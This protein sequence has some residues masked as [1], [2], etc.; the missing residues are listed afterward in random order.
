MDWL[1]HNAIAD[2]YGPTFLLVYGAIALVVIVVAYGLVHSCD[3]T[4]LRPPPPVPGIFNPY[5]IAYLRGGKNEVIRTVLYVLYQYGLVEVI[6]RKWLQGP[7]LV[8][9]ANGRVT[10]DLTE[11]EERVL[12]S[13]H[14]PVEA[15][16]LFQHEPLG[17]DIEQLCGQFRSN[18]ESDELVRPND[19][20]QAA[21]RIT[22]LAGGI[23]VALSL[24]KILI[25]VNKG[26]PNIGF[27]ILLTLLSLALL[28][29]VVG[30]TATARISNR[31]RA[32]LKR[33][34][35]AYAD[36]RQHAAP[37]TDEAPRPD[38]ASVMLISLFGLGI[39]S[40]TSEAA[41]AS[42]FARGASSSG[43]GGGCGGGGD[44]GGG[45]GGCGGCGG[46]GD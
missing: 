11:L 26:L 41:F 36:I 23:L 14:Q 13:L 30:S 10:K 28:W 39:L 32:Y 7:R 12:R 4:G 45:G 9:R 2:M 21:L 46:G 6:P 40:G 3:K 24:Y 29:I 38:M 20:R 43:C 19:I 18:L 37:R 25:A 31:G 33:L 15:S 44:G 34:Q 35:I 5:E 42:L 1:I 17:S 22:L 16:D 27:L 8:E